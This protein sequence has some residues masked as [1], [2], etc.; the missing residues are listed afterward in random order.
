MDGAG[1]FGKAF[2]ASMLEVYLDYL[3]K[4]HY[5]WLG[6]AGLGKSFSLLGSKCILSICEGK[7][8][9]LAGMCATR[10]SRAKSRLDCLPTKSRNFWLGSTTLVRLTILFIVH[11]FLGVL[12]FCVCTIFWFIFITDLSLRLENHRRLLACIILCWHCN[13]GPRPSQKLFLQDPCCTVTWGRAPT[14]NFFCTIPLA[15]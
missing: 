11:I 14:R 9:L 5:F 15:L 10:A 12:R 2:P 6:P 13:L 1:W 7:P 4:K 8:L 3:S